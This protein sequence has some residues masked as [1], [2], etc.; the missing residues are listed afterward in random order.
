Q[1][2]LSCQGSKNG[3]GDGED[4]RRP[5]SAQDGAATGGKN[6]ADDVLNAPVVAQIVDAE[7]DIGQPENLGLIKLSGG[8]ANALCRQSDIERA[9]GGELQ[10]GGQVDW[11]SL[12]DGGGCR[13]REGSGGSRLDN[14]HRREQVRLWSLTLTQTGWRLV[15]PERLTSLLCG[16]LSANCAAQQ[17]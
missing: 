12:V 13:V 10:S 3:V 5:D 8:F 9:N 16:S 4:H 2:L 6:V 14:L 1:H 15:S 11:L 17:Q 7:I